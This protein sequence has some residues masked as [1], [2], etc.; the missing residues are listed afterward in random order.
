MIYTHDVLV[1]GSVA[2]TSGIHETYLRMLFGVASPES[3]LM[4]DCVGAK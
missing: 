3:K 4:Y 1:P 2:S